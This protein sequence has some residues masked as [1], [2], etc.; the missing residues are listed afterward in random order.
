[1]RTLISLFI[2]TVAFSAHADTQYEPTVYP[3]SIRTCNYW[4]YSFDAR[5]YLCSGSPMS[6]QVVEAR[7]IQMLENRIQALESKLQ[8]LESE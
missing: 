6:M 1:M 3:T 2:A 5:G 7:G 4:T 8:A